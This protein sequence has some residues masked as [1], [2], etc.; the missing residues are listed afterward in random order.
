MTLTEKLN[1]L[2]N[3]LE[4][5]GG[6]QA[7]AGVREAAYELDRLEDELNAALDKI[8]VL[9]ADVQQAIRQSVPVNTAPR[10]DPRLVEN[11]LDL[12]ANAMGSE[13]RYLCE[14][15]ARGGRSS[16]KSAYSYPQPM[17]DPKSIVNLTVP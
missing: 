11:M 4:A 9:E 15:Y 17:Y 8:D 2:A 6:V 12:M 7:A 10:L 5:E 1:A 16:Y 13:F 14:K 3:V